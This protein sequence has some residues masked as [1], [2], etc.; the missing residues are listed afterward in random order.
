MPAATS[1]TYTDYKF[2]NG[3]TWLSGD[4]LSILRGG[5]ATWTPD[6]PVP[7]APLTI[8][9]EASGTSLSTAT[10]VEIH[11]GFD[12]WTDVTDPAMTN[13][14]GTT[15]A[16]SFTVPTN[17]SRDV[18]FVFRGYLDGSTNLTWFSH[19]KDWIL[20]MSTLVSP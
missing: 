8:E 14:A 7:D 20:Y 10:N 11:L 18:D 5:S 16:Y 6:V 19:G 12:G 3:E 9:F 15:W 1:G 2:R 4:N 13:V 17:Y